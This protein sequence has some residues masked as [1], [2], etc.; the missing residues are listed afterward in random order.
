MSEKTDNKKCLIC[1]YSWNSKVEHP[2][3]CPSCKRM[4]W[5]GKKFL[6][7]TKLYVCCD[8]GYHWKSYKEAKPTECPSCKSEEYDIL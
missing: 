4:D 8:C 5:N 7:E 1:G 2:K 3:Q 6:K